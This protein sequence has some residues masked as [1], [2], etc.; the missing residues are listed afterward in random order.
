MN[1]LDTRA[2]VA[3]LLTGAEVNI[4]QAS[5]TERMRLRRHAR[6]A[7]LEVAI[8]LVGLAY[9]TNVKEALNHAP[10]RKETRNH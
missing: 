6:A 1:K 3:E 10:D 4:G 2:V 9:V 5:R 8:V 7:G